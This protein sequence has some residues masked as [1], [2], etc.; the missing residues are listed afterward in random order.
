MNIS[1]A[2]LKTIP[3]RYIMGTKIRESLNEKVPSHD[4]SVDVY[5]KDWVIGTYT[6]FNKLQM[7]ENEEIPKTQLSSEFVT[8]TAVPLHRVLQV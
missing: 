6:T 4:A 1:R 2:L 5:L 8:E 3:F 7:K